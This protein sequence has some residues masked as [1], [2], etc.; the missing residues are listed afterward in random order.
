M[1][2]FYHGPDAGR[3]RQE[4]DSLTVRYRTKHAGSSNLFLLDASL[5][6]DRDELERTLKNRSFFQEPT[7]IAVRSTF[8][9]KASATLLRDLLSDDS[10]SG[11]RDT[12]LLVYEYSDTK[13]LSKGNKRLFT[14]LTKLAREHKEFPTLTKEKRAGWMQA[15][16]KER[17]CVLTTPVA[18]KL[19]N[20]VGEDTWTLMGEMAKLCSW[21]ERGTIPTEAVDRLAT[22]IA[23]EKNAFGLTDALAAGNKK[24][25]LKELEQQL[26]QGIEPPFI[27]TMYAFAVRS[28]LI[29]KDLSEQGLAPARIATQAGMHPFVVSKNLPAAQRYDIQQLL[30]AHAWLSKADRSTKTGQWD[31]VDALYDFILTVI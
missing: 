5:S 13:E 9:D 10:L 1:I 31:P 30:D 28:M 15:F 17:D 25:A 8:A 22:P 2:L 24:Q 27:F 18:S 20:T 11:D 21:Q 23:R 29:V 12:V 14:R 4:V 16:C 6:G 26:A 3:L 19:V 7:F